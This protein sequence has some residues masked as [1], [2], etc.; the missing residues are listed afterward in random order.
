MDP[1]ACHINI[2]LASDL[3]VIKKPIYTVRHVM[4]VNC[5]K[6][7]EKNPKACNIKPSSLMWAPVDEPLKFP[8]F[9][10]PS[11]LRLSQMCP[12]HKSSAATFLFILWSIKHNW[13]GDGGRRKGCDDALISDTASVWSPFKSFRR[14]LLSIR[15]S[16]DDER[17]SGL[18][19]RSHRPSSP[20]TGT[21]PQMK[22]WR[23]DM[24]HGW[25]SY[26]R[27]KSV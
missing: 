26:L 14:C 20:W 22:G 4:L 6:K 15:R 17:R 5:T 11:Q 13:G 23:A 21:I 24:L 19:G 16:S 8:S 3:I 1:S 9:C 27:I 12:C 10:L 25:C 2:L 7:K 18:T